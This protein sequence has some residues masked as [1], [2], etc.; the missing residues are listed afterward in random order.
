MNTLSAPG[1]V[2]ATLLAILGLSMVVGLWR[3]L[4]FELM[5]LLG[6]VV[7]YVVAQAYAADIGVHVPLGEPGS[8]LHHA[9]AFGLT[10]FATLLVWSLVARLVRMLVQATP[11]TAADRVLGAAFGLLRGVVVL[12]AVATLVAFTPMLHSPAW[13]SSQ[14][15]S[16]LGVVLQG[17]KPLLPAEVVRHFPV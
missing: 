10:F 3:G 17:I 6:W 9:I 13:A 15:A 5:S 8:A 12:L 7:A 11:L 16:W 2:D 1:W 14:G 4:V